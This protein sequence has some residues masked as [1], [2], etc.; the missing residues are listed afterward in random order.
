ME[1]ARATVSRV[2]RLDAR[3]AILIGRMLQIGVA[4]AAAVTAIGFGLLLAGRDGRAVIQLGVLIL[5][6]TPVVRVAF[7]VIWFAR[8]RDRLY[9]ALALFVLAVLALGLLG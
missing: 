5:V 1:D 9:T 6:S 3:M 4:A 2:E 8:E 7:M